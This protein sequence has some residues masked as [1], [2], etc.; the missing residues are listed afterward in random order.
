[1][2]L[3]SDTSPCFWGINLRGLGS[4][5][6]LLG[7]KNVKLFPRDPF[8]QLGGS[9]T[10]Q[11]GIASLSKSLSQSMHAVSI[12]KSD[13]ILRLRKG[14]ARTPDERKNWCVERGEIRGANTK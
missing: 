10:F 8:G 3:G 9:E 5:S 1:M 4:I 6:C 11:P 2:R 13:L 12:A 14:Q 7:G